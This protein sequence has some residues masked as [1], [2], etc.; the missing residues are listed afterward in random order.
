MK[1][2]LLPL[3]VHFHLISESR[4]FRL[5]EKLCGSCGIFVDGR[6]WIRTPKYKTKQMMEDF[7]GFRK[8]CA[9]AG[10]RERMEVM[11][12]SGHSTNSQRSSQQQ[13]L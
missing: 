5:V 9:G 13:A 7:R 4:S 6:V 12:V 8:A 1:Y 10:V 2:F 3:D 11:E